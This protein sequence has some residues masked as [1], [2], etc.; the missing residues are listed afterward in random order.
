MHV[1]GLIVIVADIKHFLRHHF[2]RQFLFLR[3]RLAPEGLL[4]LHFSIGTTLLIGAMWLF[5][6]IA[7]DLI[8]GDPLV[9]ID[10]FLSEWFRSHAEPHFTQFMQYV[11][12]L[13]SLPAVI[14]LSAIMICIVL[15]RRQWYWLLGLILVVAGGLV[16]NVLLKN[17][18]GRARPGWAD[19]VLADASFPSGHAMMATIIYG[20]VAAY[21]VLGTCS[22]LARFLIAIMA[23]ALVFLIAFSRLYLGAHYLSDVLGAMAAGVI[24]LTLC[25]TLVEILRRYR[26]MLP[27]G[28]N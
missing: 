4:G 27:D 8:T 11:S 28:T 16:L 14:V 19:S 15:W 5:G 22:M 25:L 18:F 7:E 24:W 6:G 1:D 21:L 10:A 20:F 26:R 13:A 9:L 3:A 2:P 17:L 23:I 12:A